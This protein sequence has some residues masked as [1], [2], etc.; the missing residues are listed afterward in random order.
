MV[1]DGRLA[2]VL[3]F[4]GGI[5]LETAGPRGG[6]IGFLVALAL[7]RHVVARRE[8]RLPPVSAA[9]LVAVLGAV[10]LSYGLL[11]PL[12]TTG[13]VPTASAGKQRTVLVDFHSAARVGVTVDGIH[14][15]L[16]FG[17]ALAET[18]PARVRLGSGC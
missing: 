13:V 16:P 1:S 8:V 2:A 10:V 14:A 18:L 4:T 15:P 6:L 3:F 5:P 7:V 11:H 9:A 17:G 12:W